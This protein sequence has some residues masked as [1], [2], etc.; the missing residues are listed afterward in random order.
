MLRR[1]QGF[2]QDEGHPLSTLNRMESQKRGIWGFTMLGVPSWGPY[3]RGILPFAALYSGCLVF[4]TFEAPY[5]RKP[6][7]GDCFASKKRP[8]KQKTPNEKPKH[9]AG[10]LLTQE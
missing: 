4:T 3:S 1:L 9:V 10:N 5:F 6:P 7:Y 2:S 8:W